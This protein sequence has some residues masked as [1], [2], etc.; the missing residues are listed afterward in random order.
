LAD[1][2]ITKRALANALKEL[3]VEMP[4]EK[5]NVADISGRCDMNRKSFY[6]HFKDK[7]D[8][9]NW[10]FDTEF[11]AIARGKKF[12]TGWDFMSD[13]CDYLYA[14]REF[15]RKAVKIEGQNAFP[16]HFREMLGQVIEHYVRLLLQGQEVQEFHI[17]FFGDGFVCAF[18]R[19]MKD[20][21]AVPPEEFIALLKSCIHQAAVK[22]YRDISMAETTDNE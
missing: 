6:Y 8:L 13:L 16:A 5:I 4:F 21:D 18:V 7:Y 3:M 19:W 22:V 12:E 10:I 9:V 2:N 15:Y 17:N 14:E 20:K 11:I 1:S